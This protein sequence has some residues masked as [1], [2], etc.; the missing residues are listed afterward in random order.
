MG[1]VRRGLRE[2]DLPA[3]AK[4]AYA[5][6]KKGAAEALAERLRRVDR[7]VGEGARG[8]RRRLAAGGRVGRGER[9]A[10]KASAAWT[11]CG[12]V[13]DVAGGAL[14]GAVVDEFNPVDARVKGMARA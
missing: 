13:A 6:A 8:V 9:A 2:R 12:D 11:K 7:R 1:D 10:A 14:G 5:A 3:K 4:A